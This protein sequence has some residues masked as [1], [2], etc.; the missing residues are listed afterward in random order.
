M[1]GVTCDLHSYG[2]ICKG[3]QNGMKKKKVFIFQCLKFV[4]KQSIGQFDKLINLCPF[5]GACNYLA[6]GNYALCTQ[7]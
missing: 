6:T 3:A 2:W 5:L 4:K 7:T 1:E